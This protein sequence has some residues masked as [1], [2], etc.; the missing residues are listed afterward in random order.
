MYLFDGEAD[1]HYIEKIEFEIF[2][3]DG[4]IYDEVEDLYLTKDEDY[5]DEYELETTLSSEKITLDR[6]SETMVFNRVF[7]NGENSFIRIKNA[8]VK[9]VLDILKKVGFPIKDIYEDEYIENEN[10]KFTLAVVYK[11][12]PTKYFA[13]PYNAF[14]L[15]VDFK[16]FLKAIKDLIS[17]SLNL[18]L[19]D[20]DNFKMP[21]KKSD[22][23]FLS[24]VF[25]VG[26]KSYYYL[27]DDDTLKVGDVVVVPAG[28]NSKENIVKIV[29]TEFF[30]KE[31]APFPVNN[32]KKVLRRAT[33]LE[34]K[35]KFGGKDGGKFFK[36]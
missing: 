13:G 20:M 3:N 15:P 31:N 12:K 28:I 9:Y 21:R 32:T 1:P 27:T 7:F 33:D 22:Y 4:I 2:Y 26:G 30:S 6:K 24:V 18:D 23:I 36:Y 8:R 34:I 5:L 10:E 25:S 19:F 16:E 35:L 11:N 17:T 14:R 29:K